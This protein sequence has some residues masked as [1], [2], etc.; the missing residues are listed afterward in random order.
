MSAIDAEPRSGV[1]ATLEEIDE[2]V[3]HITAASPS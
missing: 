1:S 2:G 3:S